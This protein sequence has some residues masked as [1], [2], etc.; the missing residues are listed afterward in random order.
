MTTARS[1]FRLAALVAA[2]TLTA[3]GVAAASVPHDHAPGAPTG[4]TVDDQTNPLAVQG[5]PQFGWLPRTRTATRS[6]P[7]TRSG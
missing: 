3:S 4:L 2:L 6:S 1:K 7:R 5:N